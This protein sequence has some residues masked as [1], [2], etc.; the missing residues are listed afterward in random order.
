MRGAPAG[1][2]SCPRSGLPEPPRAGASSSVSADGAGS[3]GARTPSSGG[4]SERDGRTA[5]PT[6]S[7][8][9]SPAVSASGSARRRDAD[10]SGPD[11]GSRCHTRTVTRTSAGSYSGARR[12]YTRASARKRAWE[13]SSSVRRLPSITGRVASTV[14]T[15]G[16][17]THSTRC[18]PLPNTKGALTRLS[19][20]TQ[21]ANTP[22]AT[23]K[24]PTGSGMG[25][26]KS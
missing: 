10:G 1:A 12:L 22:R 4:A 20:T 25:S 16:G 15:P 3:A 26:R 7:A 9:P 13:M 8:T 11:A 14:I 2:L 24:V 18:Q 23:P 17:T 19:R 5:V 6:V 21:S